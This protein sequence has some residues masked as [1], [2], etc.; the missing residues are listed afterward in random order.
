MGCLWIE[1][2]LESPPK[3]CGEPIKKR[4]PYCP[5][6]ERRY[7]D[8]L[9]RRIQCVV[10]GSSELCDCKAPRIRLRDA[11]RSYGPKHD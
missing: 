5:K 4:G 11:S 10:C 8:I 6:H 7:K 9:K 1:D 3:A 2:A